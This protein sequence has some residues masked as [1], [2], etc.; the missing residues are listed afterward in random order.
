MA[1]SKIRDPWF[2]R[3]ISNI[4]FLL[5]RDTMDPDGDGHRVQTFNMPAH[6][7]EVPIGDTAIVIWDI[8]VPTIATGDDGSGPRR[9]GRLIFI[10]DATAATEHAVDASTAFQPG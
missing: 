8:D 3:V 1:E 9:S 7:V 10:P 5:R 2:K 6:R 4:D